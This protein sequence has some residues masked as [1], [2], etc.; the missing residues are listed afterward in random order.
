MEFSIFRKFL[1]SFFLFA[2]FVVISVIYFLLC[3]SVK[4]KFAY[5]YQDE[6]C[7]ALGEETPE[8][9]SSAVGCSRGGGTDMGGRKGAGGE[10]VCSL[11]KL[12]YNS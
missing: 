6:L 7:S 3:E 9:G 4:K 12:C 8:L 5:F 11:K 10:E 1:S 2:K